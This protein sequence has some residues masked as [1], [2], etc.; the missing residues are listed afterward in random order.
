MA[1]WVNEDR[2]DNSAII[3]RDDRSCEVPQDKK[4]EDG[5]WRGPFDTKEKAEQVARDT[6]RKVVRGCQICNP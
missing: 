6:G 4:P 1:F 2:P 5:G 3:H